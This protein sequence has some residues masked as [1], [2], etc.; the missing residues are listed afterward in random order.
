MYNFS[1]YLHARGVIVTA[2]VGSTIRPSPTEVAFAFVVRCFAAI[3]INTS[4]V[5]S[6]GT[7]FLAIAVETAL[8]L[9]AKAAMRIG[10]KCVGMTIVKTKIAFVYIWTLRVRPTGFVCF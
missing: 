4:F 3:S 9:A 5:T 2:A 8:A 6:F 1:V 7:V 10:A